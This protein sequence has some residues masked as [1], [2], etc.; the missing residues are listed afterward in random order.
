MLWFINILQCASCA[1]LTST[2]LLLVVCYGPMCLHSIRYWALICVLTRAPLIVTVYNIGL[3]MLLLYVLYSDVV[4]FLAGLCDPH[5]SVTPLTTSSFNNVLVS[6]FSSQ[7]LYHPQYRSLSSSHVNTAGRIDLGPFKEAYRRAYPN[8]TMP[9][10]AFLEWFIGFLEGDGHPGGTFD[11]GKSYV[12]V[13]QGVYNLTVLW[14]IQAVF[15]FGGVYRQGADGKVWRWIAANLSDVYLMALLLNG[16]MCLPVRRAQFAKWLVEYNKRAT[17]IKV[18]YIESHVVPSLDHGWLS[19]F[20]DAEGSYTVST[21]QPIHTVVTKGTGLRIKSSCSQKGLD[22]KPVLDI[23]SSLYGGH[24]EAHSV[25]G[26]YMSVAIGPNNN[27]KLM[28]YHDRYPLRTNKVYAYYD[29]CSFIEGFEAKYHLRSDTRPCMLA[30]GLVINIQTNK[31]AGSNIPD[32]SPF[33][34]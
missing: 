14:Y 24:T 33:Y 13:T 27:R 11:M 3:L 32:Q 5:M 17:S 22:N 7:L 10:D 9:S 21:H 19:G 30:L 28:A 34:H 2:I 29:W 12:L 25:K 16:N 6:Y 15:G 20:L 4:L 31:R 23:I 1:T 8:N 26:N 18:Q